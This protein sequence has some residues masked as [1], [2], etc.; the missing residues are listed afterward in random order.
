ML[1]RDEADTVDGGA[2]GLAHAL[3]QLR[4]ACGGYGKARDDGAHRIEWVESGAADLSIRNVV[5]Q[6][7]GELLLREWLAPGHRAGAADRRRCAEPR[8]SAPHSESAVP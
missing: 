8:A 6:H 1:S 5:R 2:G 4:R 3:T 7:R